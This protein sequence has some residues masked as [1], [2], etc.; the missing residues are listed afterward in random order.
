MLTKRAVQFVVT[1]ATIEAVPNISEGRRK[2][3]LDALAGA[4]TQ[5]TD[6][7]LLDLSADPSHN[8]CVLTMVGDVDPLLDAL[9]GLYDV[10]LQRVD[11]RTHRGVHP[12]IGAV[13][14]VPF[15]PVQGTSMGD[16][17]ELAGRLGRA[18]ADRFSVPVFLYGDAATR[19]ERRALEVIRRGQFEG[20]AE[21]MTAD[22]WRPD[23]GPA[24]PHPSAGASAIGARGP[25]IAFNVNLKTEDL[26]AALAIARTVR[27]R[28]G[29]L[30][31]VKAIGVRLAHR[32]L[33]QVSIN[34]TDY[35]TTPLH[36]IFASVQQEASRRGIGIVESE[37]VGLVPIE[38][39]VA[40]SADAL[41]LKH[42]SQNQ[43]LEVRLRSWM[44]HPSPVSAK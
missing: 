6:V 30:A 3:V 23:I 22:A 25:L 28:N 37:V 24:A 14:V 33:V 21:K 42:F 7:S 9:L 41:R 11:L 44:S 19:P 31:G 15:V 43:V 27:E 4:V 18:V 36:R 10:A 35:R 38:A 13:D 32:G 17:V 8:R 39:M 5:V 26:D 40:A 16:C 1:M 20:L 12:R 29:G 34:L 2:E